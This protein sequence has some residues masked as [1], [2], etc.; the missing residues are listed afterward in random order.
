MSHQKQETDHTCTNAL[1]LSPPT[2]SKYHL[3]TGI[4]HTFLLDKQ[5]FYTGVKSNDNTIYAVEELMG[6]YTCTYMLSLYCPVMPSI[7]Q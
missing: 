7:A 3:Y 6:L 2:K 5:R 4:F 1:K